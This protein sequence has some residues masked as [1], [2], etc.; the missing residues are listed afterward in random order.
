MSSRVCFFA[1]LALVTIWNIEMCS[2]DPKADRNRERQIIKAALDALNQTG[3]ILGS[4]GT[5]NFNPGPPAA[6]FAA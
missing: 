1:I 4:T 2:A 6:T 3:G 5:L